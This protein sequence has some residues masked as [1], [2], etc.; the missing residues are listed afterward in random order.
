MAMDPRR[1][2]LGW[3]WAALLSC[4]PAH[5][6]ELRDD[7]GPRTGPAAS[8]VV[9]DD[10]TLTLLITGEQAGDVG[11]CGC[12]GRPLGGLARQQAY[13]EAVEATGTPSLVLNAGGWLDARASGTELTERAQVANQGFLKGLRRVRVDVLNVGW[14]EFAALQ[15]RGRPGLVASGLHHDQ[16]VLDVVTF[17]VGGTRVAVTGM[18]RPGMPYLM[19]EGTVTDP[20]VAGVQ[21]ALA[22]VERDLAVVLVYDDPEGARA[23]S[24][25]PGVD[26]VVDAARFHGRYDP[27][28]DGALHVRTWEQGQRLTE[29]RLW[30]GDEG[31]EEALVRQVDLDADIGV[32]WLPPGPPV[33][34][35]YRPPDVGS[36]EPR[37]TF[38]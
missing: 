28:T 9:E 26:L 6:L 24:M 33:L 30:L 34:E 1:C 23:V 11:A 4:A 15:G 32:A 35:V 7:P 29:V 12:E 19:P 37:A 14:P 36:G 27:F 20:A 10:A 5:A 38:P 16:P 21:T 25:L 13:V 22:G 3:L 17:D 2:G 8:R 18:T 31:I